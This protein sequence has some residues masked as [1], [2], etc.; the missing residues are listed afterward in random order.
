[1]LADKMNINTIAK[2]T[3]LSIDEIKNSKNKIPF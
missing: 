3:G 2:F 1:M